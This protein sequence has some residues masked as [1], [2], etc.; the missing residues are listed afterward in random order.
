MKKH[1]VLIM[2]LMGL[3][4]TAFSQVDEQKQ[5]E[6]EKL[7]KNYLYQWTDDRGGIHITDGLGKVPA[8]YRKKAVKLEQPK[9]EGSDQV[10]QEQGQDQPDPY[11][12]PDTGEADEAAKTEWRRRMSE[13]KQQLLN[14]EQRYKKLDKE[15]T[16]LLGVM[17]PAAMAPIANKLRAEAL[18]EEMK[19]VRQEI[20]EDR[21]Q[22]EVAFPEEARKAGVPPGWLRE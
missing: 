17:G 21:Y 3:A 6:E 20:E 13:T 12:A 10:Q 8:E 9:T 16:D 4:V 18:A 7:K 19:N 5:A 15:R 2:V 14:A 11:S 22:L 1:F